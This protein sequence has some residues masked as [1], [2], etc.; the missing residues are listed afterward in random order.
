LIASDLYN[1]NGLMVT[2]P[3]PA[4]Y[5]TMNR[6]VFNDRNNKLYTITLKLYYISL[7][8]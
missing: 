4:N 7:V 2:L 5:T 3:S 6:A 8:H 1:Q